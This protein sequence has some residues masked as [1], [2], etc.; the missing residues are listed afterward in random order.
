MD[1]DEVARFVPWFLE[2]RYPGRLRPV[3]EGMPEFGHQREVDGARMVIRSGK[4][5]MPFIWVRGGV[6]HAVPRSEALAYHVASENRDLMVGRV[7]LAYGDELALVAFDDAITAID[8]DPE[9]QSSM[10][11]LV[12]RFEAS[13]D[14]TRKWTETILERFGGKPFADEDLT[15]LTF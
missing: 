11:D 4:A 9:R 7:Y 8:L 15:L 1:N 5:R 13:L 10:Q 3:M 6:A 14:Y 12:N 2:A